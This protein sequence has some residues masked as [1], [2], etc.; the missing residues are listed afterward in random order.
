MKASIPWQYANNRIVLNLFC[1]VVAIFFSTGFIEAQSIPNKTVHFSYDLNGNRVLRW[2]QINKMIQVDSS[3]MAQHDSFSNRKGWDIKNNA[4]TVSIFPN[5][6]PGLLV[7]KIGG[8][9]EDVVAEVVLINLSGQELLRKQIY[10]QDSK[11]DI[12][13]FAPGTYIVVI[14]IGSWTEKWKI[15]KEQ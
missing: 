11:I 8:A 7:L 2:I 14:Q 3:D 12:S 1:I 9:L 6:T 13:S 10:S 4:W 15:I 5:P